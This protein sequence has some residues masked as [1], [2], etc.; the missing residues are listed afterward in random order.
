M[1]KQSENKMKK[2]KILIPLLMFIFIL[3]GCDLNDSVSGNGG[4]SGSDIKIIINEFLAS[5]DACCT[6]ENG[7][8][9]DWFEIYN[10]GT[11]TVDIGGMYTTDSKNDYKK[12]QFPA[13]DPAATTIPPGGFLV[14]WCD[15]QPEQGPLHTNFALGS[16][17]EDIALT[18]SNG[19]IIINELTYSAQNTDVSEGR[20][21]DGSDTW[22]NFSTPTPGASNSGG[23]SSFP[24]NI[25]NIT[26]SPDPINP[27]D[28]VT[29]AATVTDDDND[30]ATVTLTYGEAGAITTESPMA[31]NGD[32]YSDEIGPFADG[33]TIFFFITA[34]DAETQTTVSDTLS[35]QVGFVPPVLFINEFLAS[36]DT[37][38]YDPVTDD[39]PDWIEIYNPGTEAVDVGGMYITDDLADLT[40]WQIP[41]TAPD[42]TTIQPGGFLL[43]LADKLPEFGVLHVNIKLGSGGEQIGLTAS[44]GTSV[45]DSLTYGPQTTDVSKGRFPDGSN[46][47]QFFTLP[48]PGASNN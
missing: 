25:S 9:D 27:T 32:I 24:P 23:G 29:I 19:V 30:L 7:E 11:D 6:D 10:Y 16:G 20:L 40:Q 41:S 47:W 5:N 36:N 14:V 48:T 8:F 26:I 39:Y 34:V 1:E 13:T 3:V 33:T 17:G 28:M 46:N 35:F 22:Q 44:N 18:E 2:L 31:A 38:F 12:Y 45:I 4:S 21:P 37:S 15:G 42:T 43:L